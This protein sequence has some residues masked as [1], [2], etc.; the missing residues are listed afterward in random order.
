MGIKD[1]MILDIPAPS[2]AL[3]ELLTPEED[4]QLI[5][6]RYVRT[7]CTP[8][9]RLQLERDVQEW[10]ARHDRTPAP[11]VIWYGPFSSSAWIGELTFAAF[12]EI[13][14]SEPS[15]DGLHRVNCREEGTVGHL[16]CGWCDSHG[17]PRFRCGCL[18][19]A[20]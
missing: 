3:G 9:R 6:E 11:A 19:K 16:M 7:L 18:V 10:A 13:V 5:T 8:L 14:G 4:L 1:I 15:L 12:K 17:A 20:P 2:S